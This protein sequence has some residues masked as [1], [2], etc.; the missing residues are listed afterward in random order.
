MKALAAAAEIDYGNLSKLERGETGY[1]KD[2]LERIARVLNVSVGV[3]FAEEAQ[4]E[5]AALRMRN[6]PVLTETQ[7]KQWKG[8]GS[9][10]LEED[11]RHLHADL[12]RMTRHVFALVVRDKSN[13]PIFLEGDELI[14]DAGLQ[15][16][17]DDVVAA[18]D[19]FGGL[20]IGRFRPLSTKPGAA[21][22]F[23]ILP[24]DVQGKVASTDSSPGLTLRGTLVEM[25]RYFRGVS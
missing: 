1:S 10:P 23:E 5:A 24:H 2:A 7:L 4:V 12:S 21:P 9:L 17:R 3:L 16:G 13:A 22:A 6:V 25:R 14:F 18:Q 11:H 8:S 19:A 15:P 20:H